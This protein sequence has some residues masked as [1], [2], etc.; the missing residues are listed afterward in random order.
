MWPPKAS[1]GVAVCAPA[2]SQIASLA[3]CHR[4]PGTGWVFWIF[5]SV[6]MPAFFGGL[7]TENCYLW[8]DRCGCADSH[9]VRPAGRPAV[10][11]RR[12]G[13]PARGRVGGGRIQTL[14][15]P[16]HTRPYF[17][18]RA[19]IRRARIEV[20]TSNG[21]MACAPARGRGGDGVE[22]MRASQIMRQRYLCGAPCKVDWTG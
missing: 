7:C 14:I 8:A 1:P 9:G 10:Q 13:P 3:A 22:R 19:R 16:A 21:H 2:V 17:V 18:K 12:H 20:M 15:V 11:S 4:H 6:H 5:R